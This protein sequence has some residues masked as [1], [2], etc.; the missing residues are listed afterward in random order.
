MIASQ[1]AVR[2]SK[3]NGLPRRTG[4]RSHRNRNVVHHVQGESDLHSEKLPVLRQSCCSQCLLPT[5]SVTHPLCLPLLLKQAKAGPA[6]ARAPKHTVAS[7]AASAVA[8][9]AVAG[10]EASA[11]ASTQQAGLSIQQLL[12]LAVRAA[13]AGA[14]LFPLYELT[15]GLAVA[16]AVATGL[17]RT[18]AC[19]CS[20]FPSSR[21][22]P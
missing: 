5:H 3:E 2:I 19:R 7:V 15:V 14:R 4:S 21:H 22:S 13:T 20:C 9:S 16:W 6:L 8:A 11:V 10:V 12:E 17:A 18:S 1:K